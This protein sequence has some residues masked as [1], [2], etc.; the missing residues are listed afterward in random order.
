MA[1]LTTT[2]SAGN[3]Q[4]TWTGGVGPFFVDKADS[5]SGSTVSWTQVAGPLD[6]NSATLPASGGQGYYRVRSTE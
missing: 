3:A 5:L 1:R 4:F 6:G 2:V